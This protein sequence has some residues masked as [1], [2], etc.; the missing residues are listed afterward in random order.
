MAL[1]QEIAKSAAVTALA[2]LH[3]AG[4]QSVLMPSGTIIV[5]LVII[6]AVSMMNSTFASPV[7][8]KV[9]ADSRSLDAVWASAHSAR[10]AVEVL[11]EHAWARC[12]A[13]VLVGG[14]FA[15]AL[16]AAGVCGSLTQVCAVALAVG[17]LAQ[18]LSRV[19]RSP[20]ACRGPLCPY[21]SE[22]WP[23]CEA[24]SDE[25]KDAELEF[26]VWADGDLLQLPSLEEDTD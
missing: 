25:S 15:R 17:G 24:S 2:F 19:C 10:S 13:C 12:A 4:V 23:A 22:F 5:T 7:A 20:Q 26:D 3:V 18:L 9:S 21:S 14:L 6:Q 1:K 16:R 11:F 8:K